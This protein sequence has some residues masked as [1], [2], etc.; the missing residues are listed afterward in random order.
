M[1]HLNEA[2]DGVR[3]ALLLAVVAVGDEEVADDLRFDAGIS[4]VSVFERG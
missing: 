1:P 2:D 4:S 3:S